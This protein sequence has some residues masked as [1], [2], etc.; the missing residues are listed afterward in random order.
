MRLVEFDN[1]RFAGNADVA[2]TRMARK[3]LSVRAE[4][5]DDRVMF[6]IAQRFAGTCDDNSMVFNVYG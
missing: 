6:T 3:M 4:M 5:E 2:A 1:R